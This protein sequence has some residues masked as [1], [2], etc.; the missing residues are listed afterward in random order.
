MKF[1]APGYLVTGLVFGA[2]ISQAAD[3]SASKPP[4][5]AIILFDGKN[6]D[7]W[8]KQKP[9]EWLT[10]DGP[11][12]GWK[13]VEGGAVEVVP[14]SGCIITKKRFGD[15]KIHLEFRVLGPV[16]SGVFLQA[17][18]EVNIKDSYN[19]A[20]G[21]P[22]C[23][24]GNFSGRG[25]PDQIINAAASPLQWQTLDI[26][27]HAPRFDKD[28][29]KIANAR[30][31]TVF[32]GVTLYKDVEAETIKGAAKRLG[33]APKGPLML[34]EHGAPIQFRNIWLVEQP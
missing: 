17:R 13:F 16:N 4:A 22:C 3:S 12:S 2:S 31:T 25:L 33:E 20:K 23:A 10:E 14:D 7:A 11:A 21:E 29:T 18:Y 5:G 8:A 6:L 1:L 27:F 28:G 32:N 24:P 26:D 15:C 34:Q 19:Q 30:I 9:K